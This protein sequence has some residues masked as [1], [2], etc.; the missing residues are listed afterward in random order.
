MTPFPRMQEVICHH[1]VAGN[2]GWR[3]PVPAQ[4]E[5]IV[6]DVLIDLLDSRVFEQ[7]TQPAQRLVGIELR[8]A[9]GATHWQ[10]PR[11]ARLPGEGVTN[12][13]AAQRLQA[14][15]LQIDGE[16]LLPTQLIEKRLEARR[17]IDQLVRRLPL[18]R[19]RRRY[20]ADAVL[21]RR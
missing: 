14:R 20:V 1:R 2:T 11:H 7:R 18:R 15:R 5:Q 12:D 4:D 19:S 10:I 21:P 17:R 9:S 8:I 3:G 13:L 16:P 6:L